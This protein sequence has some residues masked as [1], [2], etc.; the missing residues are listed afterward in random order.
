MVNTHQPNP[1]NVN[2]EETCGVVARSL[3]VYGGVIVGIDR[4]TRPGGLH[5]PCRAATCPAMVQTAMNT[6]K[7]EGQT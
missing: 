3:D 7:P 2:A 4:A 5:N 1:T 6:I